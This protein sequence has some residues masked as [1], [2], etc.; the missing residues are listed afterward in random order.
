LPL[1]VV[2]V[3]MGHDKLKE[4]LLLLKI[5]RVIW[6]YTVYLRGTEVIN[7]LSQELVT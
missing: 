4:K 6:V 3:Y 1:F 5:S 7:V 2:L